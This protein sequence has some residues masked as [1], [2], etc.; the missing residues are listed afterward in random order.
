MT[1]ADVDGLHPNAVAHFLPADS[2]V[3]KG[4]LFIAQPPHVKRGKQERYTKD[5]TA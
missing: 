1:D 3:E 5:E 2:T 4:H